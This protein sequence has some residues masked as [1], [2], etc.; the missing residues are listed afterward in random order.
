M[1]PGTHGKDGREYSLGSTAQPRTPRLGQ[2]Q[3]FGHHA[4]PGKGGVAVDEQAR[5]LAG[6]LAGAQAR[7]HR[8]HKAHH[9]GIDRLQ[10]AGVGR[11]RDPDL[12]L[13]A[14]LP[15]KQTEQAQDCGSTCLTPAV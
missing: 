2:L 14:P 12:A 11:N 7:L 8:A 4:Q 10:V 5:H 3:A 15:R 13:L 1:H 9:H 6:T